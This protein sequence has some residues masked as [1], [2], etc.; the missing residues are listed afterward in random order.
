M[1][2]AATR[3]LLVVGSAALGA[4]GAV[5]LRADLLVGYGFGKAFEARNVTQPPFELAIPASLLENAEVGDEGYWLARNGADRR[6]PFDKPLVVGDRV[7]IAGG[8]G[9]ARTLEVVD[10]RPVAAP[11]L[12]VATGTGATPLQLVQVTAR[13]VG[14]TENDREGLVRFYI[15]IEPAKPVAVPGRRDRVGGRT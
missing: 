2:R 15:E 7:T 12:K 10:I 14:A 11:V 6:V 8:N 3:L 1:L 4:A 5:A 9:H 13:V